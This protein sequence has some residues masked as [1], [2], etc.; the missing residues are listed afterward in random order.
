MKNIIWTIVNFL[1]VS[2]P[3]LWRSNYSFIFVLISVLSIAF[4]YDNFL[5]TLMNF[6]KGKI[7]IKEL[8][9]VYISDEHFNYT[10]LKLFLSLIFTVQPI[11]TAILYKYNLYFSIPLYLISALAFVG[12]YKTINSLKFKQKSL[13]IKK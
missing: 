7:T 13:I 11:S 12:Y 10:N 2:M 3:I 8:F 1:L 5:L 6:V 4:L 9:T